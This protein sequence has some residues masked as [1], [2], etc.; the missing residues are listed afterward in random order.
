MNTQLLDPLTKRATDAFM[1]RVTE[2][3]DTIGAVL[4]G[5]RAKQS[6]RADSDAD[7]AVLLRGSHQRFTKVV[8][9][10]DA[11]AAEVLLETGIN[12][13]PFPIW[14]D[15]WEHPERYPNPRL[16]ANIARDGILL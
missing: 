13:E 2:R 8:W 6:H 10:M 5:S 3:W 7:V 4:F 14:Q 12:I 9:D 16:L 1:R 11:V 15:E